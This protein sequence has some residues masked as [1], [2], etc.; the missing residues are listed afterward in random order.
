MLHLD[1]INQ[2]TYVLLKELS[3]L[4]YLNEFALAG[5]TSLA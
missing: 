1:S 2:D 4:D 3:S 5:G